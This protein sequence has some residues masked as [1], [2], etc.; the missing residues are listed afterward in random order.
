MI[1][2]QSQAINWIKRMITDLVV[3]KSNS[4]PN[5]WNQVLKNAIPLGKTVILMDIN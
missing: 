5:V 4:D 1:D 2:P 3:M